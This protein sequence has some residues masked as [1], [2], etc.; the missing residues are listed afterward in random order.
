M[1]INNFEVDTMVIMTISLPDEMIKQLDQFMSRY[2]YSSKSELVRDAL[3]HYILDRIDYTEQDEEIT[4]IVTAITSREIK[5]DADEKII[6]TAHHYS[7]IVKVIQHYKINDDLCI[8]IILAIGKKSQIVE[9]VRNMRRIK[10]TLNVWMHT[11]R[12]V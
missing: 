12:Y 2:G 7:D 8:N 11:V 3:R 5:Y 10:G 4:T 6:Q 1:Y 9:M